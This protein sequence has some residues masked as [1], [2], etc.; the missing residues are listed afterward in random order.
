MVKDAKTILVID[1]DIDFQ[2]M[3]ST[4]LENVGYDVK[5]LVE[6]KLSSV[7]KSA[8]ACDMILMDV[9]LPGV[10]GVDL[11]KHLKSTPE[12]ETIPIILVTGHNESEKLFSESKADALIKK[13]FSFSA[14]LVKITELLTPVYFR[15]PVEEK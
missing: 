7:V 5:Y 9:E 10:S 15:T 8:K 11:T 12:I 13:P 14:L 3:V 4:M 1:D 6:G 2:F